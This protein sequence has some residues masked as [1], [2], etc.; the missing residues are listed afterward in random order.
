M[1]VSSTT[2]VRSQRQLQHPGLYSPNRDRCQPGR[3]RCWRGSQRWQVHGDQDRL[4]GA[5]IQVPLPWIRPVGKHRS[6]S[7]T[8][9]AKETKPAAT[10]SES[11]SGTTA[12]SPQRPTKPARNLMTLFTALT[13]TT[14][15]LIDMLRLAMPEL[16]CPDAL[17]TST[18]RLKRRTCQRFSEEL[19]LRKCRGK[20]RR[21]GGSTSAASAKSSSRVGWSLPWRKS[22]TLNV[23]CVPT[24]GRSSRT[25][26]S[27]ATPRGSR[28]ASSVSKNFWDI[29]GVLT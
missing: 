13:A 8:T 15:W 9:T 7:T 2:R 18:S 4:R 27:R 25:G 22:S 21:T 23:S 14:V 12:Q 26:C 28:T 11:Q 16:A 17:A 10:T 1:G 20:M 3:P 5:E 6:C 29:L 24:A 19:F